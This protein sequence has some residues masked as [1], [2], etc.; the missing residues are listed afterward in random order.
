ML[1]LNFAPFPEMETERLL[2]RNLTEDDVQD[3]FE[4]RGDPEIMQYIPR[5]IA[6]NP[7]DAKMVIEMMT[8]FTANNEKINW[9][10][11]EKATGKLLG[12]FGFVRFNYESYRAEVGYILNKNY[13]G[14]GYAKEALAPILDYGFNEM[15][16]HSIEAVIRAE[17][18][19]SMKLIEKFGF[20]KDAY[21][22]DYI[23]HNGAFY[24]AVVY[25]LVKK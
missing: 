14:K 10:V 21:F 2:L 4:F 6:Q 16:L 20:T 12:S 7:E 1:E 5:P 19:P 23:N 15:G 25:S 8:G 17:N 11:V 18:T 9:G 24:D 22:K 3:V 13:H